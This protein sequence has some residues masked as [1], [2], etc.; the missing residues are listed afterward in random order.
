MIA[1]ACD[2][3]GVE[4]KRELQRMLEDMGYSCKD[5]GNNDTAGGDD[6][7]V[8]GYRAA[9]AV[10][11]GE[12]DR[13]VL[14][15]GTGV[16]IGLA[17]NKVKGIRCVTCSEP[18]SA[19]LSKRHND[20]NMISIGSRVVGI[21]LAKMIVAAWLNAQFEGGRHA[22]RVEMLKVIEQGGELE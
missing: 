3:T 10:A 6:Y 1:L 12:C 16:G 2:H 14:I 4:M 15:C 19:Q 7:P 17:A 9:K 11:S 21:E 8:F 22:R 13:G 5:F 20:S 18:Y